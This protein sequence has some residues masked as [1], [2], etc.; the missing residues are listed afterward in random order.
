M[1]LQLSLNGLEGKKTWLP[2][3]A[4]FNWV[5]FVSSTSSSRNTKM[6]PCSTHRTAASN[7]SINDLSPP[8]NSRDSVWCRSLYSHPWHRARQ[9]PAPQPISTG[10]P[11]RRVSTFLGMR[12]SMT[13]PSPHMPCSFHPH[14]RRTWS[15]EIA[16]K[17]RLLTY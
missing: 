10:F 12:R 9:W 1:Q 4:M 15:S 14:A 2:S 13:R 5:T 16:E 8:R 7:C 11:P 17:T 6:S 3:R